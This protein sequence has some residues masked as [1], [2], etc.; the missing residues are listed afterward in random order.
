M[1][2][3]LFFIVTMAFSAVAYSQETI[4]TNLHTEDSDLLS[5]AAK[6]VR[7]GYKMKS[8]LPLIQAVEIYNHLGVS[9]DATSR[10]KKT[11]AEESVA[12]EVS[13]VSFEINQLMADATKYADG[14]VNLLALI[15]SLGSTRGA[16]TGPKRVHD[17]VPAK[18]IHS[19]E[20]TFSGDE[21]A[22]ILLNGDGVSNLELSLYDSMGH[23]IATDR[24][25]SYDCVISFSPL[26]TADYIINVKNLGGS[27]C[28]YVLATN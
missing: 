14:D 10:L 6:L 12:V 28:K 2:K 13:E 25:G 5:T 11:S 17:V 9:D 3:K 24:N 19:Y 7:Y 23:R 21:F 20:I 16:E 27:A 22:M 26:N 15:K 4:S 8:A 1:F 18:E